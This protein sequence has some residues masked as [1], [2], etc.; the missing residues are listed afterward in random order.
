[1]AKKDKKGAKAKT[2]APAKKTASKPEG[3]KR[4]LSR[5]KVQPNW[6]AFSE[7]VVANGGPKI[8][9]AHVGIVL[10]GYTYYQKSDAAKAS[11]DAAAEKRAAADAAKAEGKA[12][13]A[14]ATPTAKKTAAATSKPT[15]T[16]KKTAVKAAAKTAGKSKG[17]KAP[18]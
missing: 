18:Y 16:A 5:D 6:E 7:F 8:D 13:A 14:K 9:P 12:K 3:I 1:M 2:A 10:S 17:G 4:V 11:R 15:A